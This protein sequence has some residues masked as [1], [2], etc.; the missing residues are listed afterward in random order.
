MAWHRVNITIHFL[1]TE[2]IDDNESVLNV[3]CIKFLIGEYLFDVQ[4]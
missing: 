4:V 1:S 3:T 2:F